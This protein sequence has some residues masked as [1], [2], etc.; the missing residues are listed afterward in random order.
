MDSKPKIF[1]KKPNNDGF[2]MNSLASSMLSDISKGI[3]TP[4]LQTLHITPVTETIPPIEI[5]KTKPPPPHPKKKSGKVDKIDQNDEKDEKDGTTIVKPTKPASKSV[6]KPPKESIHVVVATIEAGKEDDVHTAA[7][8]KS[9]KIVKDSE[10]QN[11]PNQNNKNEPHNDSNNKPNPKIREKKLP[12]EKRPVGK[13]NDDD[14]D[15]DDN[16]ITKIDDKNLENNNRKPISD[17]NNQKTPKNVQ[18]KNEKVPKI[19]K[20]VP[21]HSQ[22]GQPQDP[23]EIPITTTAVVT[24]V[25]PTKTKP[26][27]KPSNETH[28][29]QNPT[30]NPPNPK[31][32]KNPPITA[33]PPPPSPLNQSTTTIVEPTPTA[34][35]KNAKKAPKPI[36]PKA[37]KKT[38]AAPIVEKNVERNNSSINSPNPEEL[39]SLPLTIEQ[40][41]E[42]KT[43]QI[44]E[45]IQ[46]E[47]QIVPK[48]TDI[49]SKPLSKAKL[50]NTLKQSEKSSTQQQSHSI[51]LLHPLQIT[52]DNTTFRRL[53][54]KMN[55]HS[56]LSDAI[57]PTES[58]LLQTH[59]NVP[60]WL[61]ANPPK[62]SIIQQ[63]RTKIE[64]VGKKESFKH[65]INELAPIEMVIMRKRW[66]SL[67]EKIDEKIIQLKPKF[68]STSLATKG[69]ASLFSS[70]I[71]KELL[72]LYNGLGLVL[73]TITK[74]DQCVCEFSERVFKVEKK[75]KVEVEKNEK[76]N[77]IGSKIQNLLNVFIS[78]NCVTTWPV[79]FGVKKKSKGT[80]VGYNYAQLVKEPAFI[81]FLSYTAE[82][83]T[84][85][86]AKMGQ[87]FDLF[88]GYLKS[89][90]FLNI[91][92][93][94]N[95]KNDSKSNP[96]SSNL[97]LGGDKKV[98]TIGLNKNDNPKG[99]NNPSSN[100]NNN[101]NNNNNVVENN[102][103]KKSEQIDFSD[104]LASYNN[105][106][107]QKD[108]AE[109]DPRYFGYST[110]FKL[111]LTN[112]PPFITLPDV[113]Q[114]IHSTPAISPQKD[115]NNEQYNNNT[116]D[117]DDRDDKNDKNDKNNNPTKNPPQHC[118]YERC[119]LKPG[120][121]TT[122]FQNQNDYIPATAFIT[123][124]TY[125]EFSLFY[126]TFHH[127]HH[128]AI[129]PSNSTSPQLKRYIL[130][131]ELPLNSYVPLIALEHQVGEKG[132]G[133]KN[134]Q[135]KNT[136]KSKKEQ[137]GVKITT[138]T[139]TTA[140]TTT[141]TTQT[142][143]QP[144]PLDD[145][146]GL[147]S[148][149]KWLTTP[150]FKEFLSEVVQEV[151]DAQIVS[152][153]SRFSEKSHSARNNIQLVGSAA[154]V[155]ELERKRKSKLQ[156]KETEKLKLKKSNR[157]AWIKLTKEED[158]LV[159]PLSGLSAAFGYG[160][161]V[162]RNQSVDKMAL[163]II[164]QLVGSMKFK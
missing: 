93:Q 2:D 107:V 32:P 91:I 27:T 116:N 52:P 121:M 29:Q 82:H 80:K 74:F 112:L 75:V 13:G 62:L 109:V 6:P 47:A 63:Y 4:S 110:P 15:D 11:T 143:I 40:S 5:G 108:I 50:T 156:Q 90:S 144:S 8:K 126:S 95:D 114:L 37:Q 105:Q 131:V 38:T 56:R 97:N 152:T 162:G 98:N 125:T 42:E 85:L 81:P 151:K 26:K 115:K 133:D 111:A 137:K 157:K 43:E 64:S 17:K 118:T 155:V 77:K 7:Q 134:D 136:K 158:K 83:F 128:H 132:I 22:S 101:N 30:L 23:S 57:S 159:D 148:Q 18:N 88:D 141:T 31:P 78:T 60:A 99:N 123:F 3:D 28:S 70:K 48:S 36:I 139:A 129:I 21:T 39:S 106:N 9:G 135:N 140:T 119:W 44:P 130:E 163:P 96:K 142:Q 72:Q 100:N 58:L 41:P 149:T 102:L 147:I 145:Q 51:E 19:D 113:H 1:K 55:P 69:K 45:I 87:Q 94:S 24:P 146:D 20:K 34:E 92:E 122:I 161:G 120:K 59:G 33:S 71:G 154:L 103:N 138:S 79:F 150:H 84:V 49:I 61:Q 153:Y 65:G 25:L 117:K 127:Y 53:D 124:S 35:T 164:D 73:K 12:K 86:K 67:G 104:F 54:I 76:N 16:N 68:W 160:L 89:D 14:D 46:I 10:I 66:V